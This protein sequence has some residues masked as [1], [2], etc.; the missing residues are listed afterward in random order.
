ME[1]R[2]YFVIAR[3][4]CWLILLPAVVAGLYG[5][6]T[7]RPP[8]PTFSAAIRYTAGQPSNRWTRPVGLWWP[9]PCARGSIGR[10]SWRSGW[11][12]AW[13]WRCWRTIWTHSFM[14]GAIW[15]NWVCRSWARYPAPG[16]DSEGGP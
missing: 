12:W 1:L 8:A 3:R 10:S 14:T 5:A 9:P 13:G 16:A 11:C 7:Y 2:D 6:A 4:W 15:T